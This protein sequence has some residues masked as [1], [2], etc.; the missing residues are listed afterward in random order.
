MAIRMIKT[1]NGNPVFA[2]KGQSVGQGA[3]GGKHQVQADRLAPRPPGSQLRRLQELT[4]VGLPLCPPP[5]NSGCAGSS[6]S[7]TAY[8]RLN[9]QKAQKL[10]NTSM[11]E[12]YERASERSKWQAC[13]KARLLHSSARM[14]RDTI[15]LVFPQVYNVTGLNVTWPMLK[16]QF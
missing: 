14:C 1:K 5:T 4:W 11:S 2:K 3:E 13:R 10:F 6:F 8:E 12:K 7:P 16:C 15:D 9:Q